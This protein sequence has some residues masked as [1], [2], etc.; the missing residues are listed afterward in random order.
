MSVLLSSAQQWPNAVLPP[1]ALHLSGLSLSRGKTVL[2]AGLD[3]DISGGDLLWVGGDNGIGKS[4]LL[5]LITGLLP[6]DTGSL[7]WSLNG[8]PCL[9]QDLIAYQGHNDA[10]KSLHTPREALVFWA[11]VMKKSGPIDE[12]L[13][14]IGLSRQSGIACAALSAGQKRRLSLGRLLLSQKAVW[15]LDE[16]TAAMDTDGV[17][18]I[19]EMIGRHLARGGS[20]VIASHHAPQI[21]GQRTR[22]LILKAASKA[23]RS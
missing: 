13:D 21:S 4:S 10:F 6:A 18:L 22:Q 16:P 12:L 23:A 7:H 3:I 11:Q 14:E 2:F 1:H 9:P 20:A 5:R 19:E 8:V 17:A 15:V